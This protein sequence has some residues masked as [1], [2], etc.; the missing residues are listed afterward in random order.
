MNPD[1]GL[2][3]FP[4]ID[5][6]WITDLNIKQKDKSSRE[7]IGE[8]LNDLGFDNGFFLDTTAKHISDKGLYK[9]SQLQ[10]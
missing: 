8:N 6:K 5:S 1:T 4:K 7:K 3:P 9:V 10:S 2:T